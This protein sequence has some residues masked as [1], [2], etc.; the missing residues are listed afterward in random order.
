MKMLALIIFLTI[1]A[2]AFF[3][4]FC[5]LMAIGKI[6][7]LEKAKEI[8]KEEKSKLSDALRRKGIQVDRLLKEIK[9]L[10]NK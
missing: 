4:G 1:M 9:R 10:E 5:L 8:L 2:I 3:F 7:S 6:K